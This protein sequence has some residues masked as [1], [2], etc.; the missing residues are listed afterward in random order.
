MKSALFGI[1]LTMFGLVMLSRGHSG[2]GPFTL[3]FG[4]FFSWSGIR[5]HQRSRAA[6][7]EY[8]AL[9][10]HQAEI[11]EALERGDNPDQIAQA[12]EA[13]Y[14]VA[15]V[16]TLQAVA[17]HYLFLIGRGRDDQQTRSGLNRAAGGKQETLPA[18]DQVLNGLYPRR[19]IHARCENVRLHPAAGEPGK[20]VIG[21]FLA[22]RTHLCFLASTE[23]QSFAGGAAKEF[24]T[25]FL[26][27]IIGLVGLARDLG[28]SVREELSSA[29]K[30]EDIAEVK[31]RLSL[32]GSFA[33]PWRERLGVLKEH[34]D[35]RVRPR[36]T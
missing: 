6:D 15:P 19:N 20:P 26:H 16:K 21:G 28:D 29:M 17:A 18:V 10:R 36:L 11:N 32:T 22:T 14:Q 3:A 5:S 23:Q 13:K 24:I 9:E 27:P 33:V 30:P 12:F 4:V 31:Q 34:V 1:A 7:R 35:G 25:N 2:L 8:P